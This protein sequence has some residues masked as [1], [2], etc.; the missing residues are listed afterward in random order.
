M[1]IT[2]GYVNFFSKRIYICDCD[3]VKE[4]ELIWNNIDALPIVQNARN[5][6]SPRKS[7]KPLILSYA[8]L[9]D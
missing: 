8:T 9:T 1:Y 2:V 5:A 3:I 6:V 7:P 4:G